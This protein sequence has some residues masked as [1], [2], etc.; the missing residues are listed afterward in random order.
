MYQSTPLDQEVTYNSRI[1][2][3]ICNYI[4]INARL[5]GICMFVKKTKLPAN[6]QFQE[7]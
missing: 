5:L 4:P 6:F 3:H 1:R 7:P 2:E